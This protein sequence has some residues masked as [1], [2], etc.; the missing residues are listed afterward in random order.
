MA[1]FHGSDY[2]EAFQIQI[3]TDTLALGSVARND[4]DQVEEKIQL[5][6]DLARVLRKN[7]VQAK[8]VDTPS[9]EAAWSGF[10]VKWLFSRTADTIRRTADH[11]GN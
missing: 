11:R 1:R 7:V 3:R 4:P 9:G 8:R 6:K 10:R 5:A 2:F